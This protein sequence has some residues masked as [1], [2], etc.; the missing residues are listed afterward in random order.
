MPPLPVK[1]PPVAV[2]QSQPVSAS[3]AKEESQQHVSM[4]SHHPGQIGRKI[5]ALLL[6]LLHHPAPRATG[7]KCTRR[8]ASQAARYVRSTAYRQLALSATMCPDRM[9]AAA[10]HALA[11]ATAIVKRESSRFDVY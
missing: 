3:F 4:A 10:G 8:L 6:N 9:Q 5:Q 2:A 1:T 7:T 11:L